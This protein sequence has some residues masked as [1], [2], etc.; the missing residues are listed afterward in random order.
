MLNPRKLFDDS[1]G[2]GKNSPQV[3]EINPDLQKYQLPKSLFD[4]NKNKKNE[5]DET[6]CI[7][8]SSCTSL[9]DT[10][11]NLSNQ[12]YMSKYKV[13]PFIIY[14]N[15]D[16]C[17]NS[18]IGNKFKKLSL[19]IN[20]GNYQKNNVVKKKKKKQEFV[21]REGDWSC[22]RCKNINFSFRNKCNKCLLSKEESEKKYIEVGEA[23]KK[24]ADIS[25][26][27]KKK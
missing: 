6:N 14:N 23:L 7:Q 27:N 21:E 3:K 26:Y 8:H 24:L 13:F 4:I 1:E 10:K 20:C 19:N 9:L 17:F 22:Y 2:K 25:I 12:S 18:N 5:K 16:M 15:P 11:L